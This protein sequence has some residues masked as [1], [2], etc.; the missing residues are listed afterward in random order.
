MKKIAMFF[1][2]IGIVGTV[3]GQESGGKNWKIGLNR[4]TGSVAYEY[5]TEGKT[6]EADTVVSDPITASSTGSTSTTDFMVEYILFGQ[7]GIEIDTNLTPGTR[8]F[9]FTDDHD[10]KIGDVVES[11]SNS[12]LYGLNMY[13]MDHNSGGVKPFLGLLTGNFTV[14]HAYSNG[15]DRSDDEEDTLS[16][17]KASQTSTIVIPAQVFKAG[18]DWIFDT[19]VLRLQYISILGEVNTSSA[20]GATD[21]D[22]KQEETVTLSGGYGLGI[23]GHF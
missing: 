21:L 3:Y 9:T 20:L 2:S 16:E 12:G 23:F 14:T 13:F 10:T 11:L 17:Y 15:G 6:T 18:I 19:V 1:L 7:M 22:E 5:A 4:F 8:S